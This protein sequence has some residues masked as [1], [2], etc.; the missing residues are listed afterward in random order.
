MKVRRIP[1]I[2]LA[3][4][5]MGCAA[6]TAAEDML[7]EEAAAEETAQAEAAEEAAQMMPEAEA[8]TDIIP[9]GQPAEQSASQT[10]AEPAE[11]PAEEPSA[12]TAQESAEQHAEEPSAQTVQEPTAQT[13]QEP[14]EQPAEEPTAQT[15]QE[16]AEQPVEEPAAQS[17][18]EPAVQ[19]AQ[20]PVEQPVQEPAEQSDQE[21][22]GQPPEKPAEQ[23]AEEPAA[24]ADPAVQLP[25]PTD[26]DATVGKPV[27]IVFANG[28]EEKVW[29][30]ELGEA[31]DLI[32][33]TEGL[34]VTV[35]VLRVPDGSTA[36]DE[37]A[38]EEG[39]KKALRLA[40]GVYLVCIRSAEET[41]G[42]C[43]W[44]LE[45]RQD[46]TALTEEESIASETDGGTE[47]DAD[48]LASEPGTE[49]NS[50]SEIAA[51]PAAEMDNSETE[52]QEDAEP[53]R[54]GM[55]EP[56]GTETDRTAESEPTEVSGEEPAAEPEKT[57]KPAVSVRLHSNLD[58]GTEAQPGTEVVLRAEVIGTDRPCHLQWQYSPDGG[59]T[60]VD[61]ENAAGSEN[62]YFR[63]ILDETNMHY[64]W[65]VAVVFDPA[66]E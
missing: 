33:I 16:P 50:E 26:G 59:K 11:Q 42:E 64:L 14:A 24:Q 5:M 13:A 40:G 15:V 2:V 8:G 66:E 57:E 36:I 46:E 60:A 12:Q 63:Y 52:Q 7:A 62:R 22:A 4:C 31:S 35:T 65:R 6:F 55:E 34:P 23:P 28:K 38:S 1:A 58:D 25:L 47:P 49:E 18:W 45:F 61:V 29:S 3:L 41:G 56:A 20:E 27:K 37:T 48:S 9:S 32:L 51:D 19:P 17:A 39:L 54:E 43:T 21:P 10:E 53:E 30:L 44:S